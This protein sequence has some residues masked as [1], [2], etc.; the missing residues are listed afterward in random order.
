MFGSIHNAF[1]LDI[2]DLSIKLVELKK[3]TAFG[4]KIKIALS[5]FGTI[6]MPSGIIVD[7][8]INDKHRLAEEI[9]KLVKEKLLKKIASDGVIVNLPDTQTF[10]TTV[11]LT[12]SVT[13]W[14]EAILRTVEKSIPLPPSKIYFDWRVIN[15]SNDKKTKQILLGAVDQEVANAYTGIIESAGLTPVALELGQL[16]TIRALMSYENPS[17]EPLAIIDIG[18]SRSAIII[19]DQGSAQVSL[20][21]PFS[22]KSITDVVSEALKI[23]FVEAEKVLVRCG[24]DVKECDIELKQIV[25]QLI[26][27]LALRVREAFRYYQEKSGLANFK[28]TQIILCGGGANIKKIDSV[29][30]E[31]L[32]IKTKV[33]NPLLN[34]VSD[35]IKFTDG[36]L[37]YTTAIGLALL[38]IVSFPNNFDHQ[39]NN[40]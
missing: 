15:E 36:P 3:K 27:D 32:K 30:T 25:K 31:K 24:F 17:T 19:Y 26:N 21:L 16:A 11:Q 5:N 10:M 7:G 13:D 9:K 22:V 38:P 29:L 12:N 28:P 34:L 37:S 8:K 39:N 35:K 2:N 23:S 6:P 1:G 40:T 4:K 20:S 14:D 18:A 33:G